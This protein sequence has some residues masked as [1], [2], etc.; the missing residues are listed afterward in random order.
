MATFSEY[1]SLGWLLC[2]RAWN[3]IIQS[4]LNF[5]GLICFALFCLRNLLPLGWSWLYMWFCV[6]LTSFNIISL[7]C[8]FSPS[9]NM[10][11]ENS[12]LILLHWCLQ[13]LLYLDEHSFSGFGE[14]SVT[15]LLKLFSHAFCNKFSSFFYV[16]DSKILSFQNVIKIGCLRTGFTNGCKPPD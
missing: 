15:I 4:P 13:R 5:K 3:N 14:I 8:I 10:M 1:N 9:P 7:F 2:F 6:P 12:F 16:H 11:W